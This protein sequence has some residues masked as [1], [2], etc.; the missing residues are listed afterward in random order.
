MQ[1]RVRLSSKC[2]GL[3]PKHFREILKIGPGDD[4]LMGVTEGS[5]T[6]CPK[7]TIYADYMMGLQKAVWMNVD[8]D[9]LYQ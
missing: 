7:L 4:L 8:T 2:H 5:L 1:V 9:Y 3:I 6:I